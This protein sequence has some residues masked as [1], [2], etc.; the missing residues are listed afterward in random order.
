MEPSPLP[1]LPDITVHGF[2]PEQMGARFWYEQYLQQREENQRLS[3]Q[4][5]QL[6]AEVEQLKEALR[7]LSNRNSDNSSQP[8][9]SDA[10][11]K[12]SKAIK[13]RQKKQGPKYGHDGTTRNGFAY[14]NHTV[15]LDLEHCP[16]CGNEVTPIPDA[17]VRRQQIAE[18]VDKPVEVW[19][20]QRPQFQCPVCGW[21]GYAP[22]PLG[23]REDF[24]YGAL[25]SS[26]VGW[27]GY[28]GHLSWNKQRYLVETVF[29][30][31]L[32]QGSLSKMHQ[33][34]CQSLYPS[35]QQWWQSIQQPGE[36]CLDETSY[37]LDGVN[38][39]LWVA[40]SAEV[41]VMFLA[42][43][44]GSAEVKSLLGEDFAGILSSDCWSAYNPQQA[45]AKQKCLAHIG[46]ELTALS[47]SDFA[48]NRLFA[49]QTLPIFE[50][51]RQAHKDYHAG[52]LSLE[53]LQNQRL[54]VEAQL[55]QVLDNPP[56]QGWDS[57]AQALA[58][59]FTRYWSD[60]FT[61][62]SHPEVKPDN[63]DAERALRPV[64]IH[65][66]VSGG[67]RSQWGGQL[68]ALMFSFLETTRLQGKNAVEELFSLLANAG[69]SPPLL[70]AS[71]SE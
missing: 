6:K 15:E 59:R 16:E 70:Q 9:S 41:C 43:S 3:Q 69:R 48:S 23:C 71:A 42:P 60:W 50:R 14:V 54:T 28:G 64:V 34:F 26:V 36:R 2:D 47:T 55:A 46:R 61:F 19:E 17:P 40:T 31:P 24:S 45:S 65:R 49:Q 12:K 8:P 7:K 27:L 30:I 37:R 10:Y 66:K 18:L 57:D 62:L 32:S 56:D 68:V 52:Q 4:L 38:Y 29:G 11:K 21:Q 1:V 39:W 63:N 58:N 13:P 20:Y 44:R 35:Y 5:S 33:W 51:A 53:Q 22:L 67:A 25:L